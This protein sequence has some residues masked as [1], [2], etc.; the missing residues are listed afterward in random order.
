MVHLGIWV[1]YPSLR[2]LRV[3]ALDIRF[4]CTHPPDLISCLATGCLSIWRSCIPSFPRRFP[5]SGPALHQ[6]V[7][8]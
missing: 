7:S 1:S 3:A 6:R 4:L 8:A 2:H 5:V